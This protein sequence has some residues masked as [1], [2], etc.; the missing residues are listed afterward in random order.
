MSDELLFNEEDETEVPA[1]L[2]YKVLIV[3]DEPDV[4]TVTKIALAGFLFDGCGL[5]L[6]HAYSAKEAEEVLRQYPDTAIILLDVVMESETAG[7]LLVDVIRSE[8]GLKNTRIVLRTG[9]P[10]QAPEMEVIVKYDINDYKAKSE[11]TSQ[12]L[13]TLMHTCLRSYRDIVALEQNKLGLQQVIHASKGIFDKHALD[14]FISGALSQLAYLLHLDEAFVMTHEIGVYKFDNQETKIYETYD[15][16]GVRRDIKVSSLSENIQNIL[17]ESILLQQNVFTEKCIVLYCRTQ[18]FITLF[19]V[20]HINELTP[21]DKDLINIFSENISIGL[22]NVHLE[23]NVRSSQKEIVYRLGEIVE[24]RSKETGNHVKR[25]SLYCE[26]LA[27]LLGLPNEEVE[28]I[29]L[30]SPLHDIGKIATPDAIL[31]K[32]GKLNDQEWNIMREHAQKGGELLAGSNIHL[33]QAA[34]II[35]SSHHEKWDGSGYPDGASGTNIHIYGRITALA[36]VFDALANKRCYKPAWSTPDVID[37]IREQR[38][39]HFDP[40][41]VDLLIEN[42][43]SFSIIGQTYAD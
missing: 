1:R 42:L 26:L 33:L 39:K 40:E 41:L 10:G 24:K 11:L 9:Q 19:L 16:K 21:I 35:A 6:L 31:N 43:S 12:K 17:N 37:F 29:K 23:E 2:F 3:D 18:Y 30:A 22:E 8:L 13:F 32:P 34:S 5:E 38:G 28:T 20:S 25:V 14:T 15:K 36:D 4:H 27:Q 7:L